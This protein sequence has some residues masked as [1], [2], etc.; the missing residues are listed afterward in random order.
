MYMMTRQLFTILLFLLV[1]SAA[2][3][4]D[5]VK[6]LVVFPAKQEASKVYLVTDGQVAR[7]FVIPFAA[8]A[9]NAHIR[10]RSE[11]F[12]QQ[13]DATLGGYDR[14][15]E[16]FKALIRRFEGRSAMFSLTQTRDAAQYGGEQGIAAAGAQGYGY[17]IAIDDKFSGLSMLNAVATRTDDVA[18]QTTL[19]YQVYETKQQSRL[20][21]GNASAN[22]MTKKPFRE[23][24][25]DREFF[26][27]EYPRIAD[28]IANQIVGALFRTD[29][30]HTMAKSAGR[31]AEVPQLSAVLKKHEKR[32]TYAL[33]PADNWRQTKMNTKYA[34][35]LEPKSDLRFALGLRF[36]VD[37]LVAEFG[38]EVSTV[39]DYIT[40]ML[41][42]L[43]ESGIDTT[44]FEEFKD[45]SIPSSYQAYSFQSN[46]EGGRTIVLLRI[47]NKDMIEVINV[48]VLKDFDTLYAQHRPTIEKMIADAKLTVS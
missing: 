2:Q 26:V 23:A 38:Q 1:F 34:S 44:T 12:G 3:A 20:A 41:G 48:V 21:K 36:D 22:G 14:Y 24:V 25:A 9:N 45:I 18:P 10:K 43:E 6:V 15:D 40:A 47:L 4:A 31:G 27:N 7:A 19:A 5:A 16:I 30:L 17:V 42:R 13:L 35:V 37:L 29:V 32:F 33:K 39:E 46:K 11:E 8:I 28:A